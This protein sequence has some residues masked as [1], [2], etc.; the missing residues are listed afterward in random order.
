MYTSGTTGV[1]KGVMFNHS[2]LIA[3]VANASVL[4][5]RILGKTF[6][7]PGE[8]ACQIGFLPL[9]HIF[10]F[11]QELLSLAMGTPIAYSTPYTLTDASPSIVPGERGDIFVAKPTIMLAVPLVLE[12]ISN[13]IKKKVAARGKERGTHG[14]LQYKT[15][16][17]ESQNICKNTLAF[18]KQGYMQ[19]I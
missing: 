4:A 9:A 17:F 1:P 16:H 10:E 11:T 7:R 6:D 2:T 3:G 8:N 14:G 12:R 19:G 5:K 18:G 15:M 13:G